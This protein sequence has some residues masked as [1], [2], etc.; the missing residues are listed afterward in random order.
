MALT[1]L[2][3]LALSLAALSPPPFPR[4]QQS[5]EGKGPRREYYWRKWVRRRA[6]GPSGPK[7]GVPAGSARGRRPCTAA[8]ARRRRHL[9]EPPLGEGG[10]AASVAPPLLCV[11]ACEDDCGVSVPTFNLEYARHSDDGSV[12][13]SAVYGTF[14]FRQ[15]DIE[16]L[17]RQLNS[18][19]PHQNSRL[20]RVVCDT[21]DMRQPFESATSRP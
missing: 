17:P 11:C 5:G 19:A 20:E 16:R 2:K 9:G 6:C 18:V 13:I 7:L 4:P 3:A 10:G 8:Q 21:V 15:V 12:P 14:R 1:A